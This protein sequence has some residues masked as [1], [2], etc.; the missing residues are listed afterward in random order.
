LTF[1][2]LRKISYFFFFSF[3]LASSLHAQDVRD[4]FSSGTVYDLKKDKSGKIW[5]ATNAGVYVSDGMNYIQI[6]LGDTKTTN[7]SIKELYV[8]NESLFLIFQ[9]SGLM[10]LNTVT[11]SFFKITNMSI[12]SF[13]VEDHKKAMMLTK[14]GGIYSFDIT[15]N[16]NSRMKLLFQFEYDRDNDSRMTFYSKNYIIV[17]ITNKGLFK[18]NKKQWV[19]EKK[20]NI[21]PDGYNNSFTHL[22]DRLFYINQSQV[23]E[24]NKNDQFIKSTYVNKNNN[25]NISYILPISA[26]DKI[27][28]K[29][30]KNLFLES[31]NELIQFNLSKSKNYEIQSAIYLSSDNI[32]F[33]SNQG[34]LKVSN[35]EIK[36]KSISDSVVQMSDYVNIRRKI[37]SYKPN[38]L[39]LFGYPKSHLYNL[40]TNQFTSISNQIN[41]LYDAIVI[42]NTV[43]ATSEGGGVKKIELSNKKISNIVTKDIDTI[44]LYKAILN[45][46]YLIKDHILIG[47]RGEL[48]FYN[49]KNNTSSLLS[50]NNS[51]ARVNSMI[52]DSISK[53]IFIGTSNGLYAYNY[54]NK[55]LIKKTNI[56]GMDIA[57]LA[58][59]RHNTISSLWFISDYGVYAFEIKSNKII[60]DLNLNYFN[61]SKLTSVLIDDE[62][63]I[64]VSSY[65]GIYFF[66]YP[67]VDIIKIN[68]KNGL[69]NQEY[70]YKSSAKLTND[71]LIFGGLNGYDIISSNLFKSKNESLKGKILGYNIYG[72]NSIVYKNYI[73]S[74]IIE[75]NTKNY[76][77]ELYFSMENFEK[78]K[79]SNFEYQIDDRPWVPLLGYSY[80]YMY[81]LKD[82]IHTINIRGFDEEGNPIVFDTI[83]VNQ[84]TDFI[85][86]IT[87]RY[88][89]FTLVIILLISIGI[90]AYNNNKKIN[91]IKS[92]IAMDLHDDI[93]TVLTRAL[94]IIKDDAML[95][96]NNNL[97]NYLSE[98]LFSIRTYINTFVNNQIPI[99]QFIDEIIEHT[100]SYFKNSDI[101]ISLTNNI[102][103]NLD[104]SN[105]LYRDL[106]LIIYEINQ[107]ILKHSNANNVSYSF[108]YLNSQLQIVIKDDGNLNNIKDIEKKGNGITNIRKRV[109]RIKGGVDFQI[110]PIGNGLMIEIKLILDK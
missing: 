14:N 43:Y 65:N 10:K 89:L 75:Y 86:S 85:S 39:L 40:K 42:G 22:N 53:T 11:L 87:L 47:R 48:I 84:R 64:W 35:V 49:I 51:S 102:I 103:N 20:Y 96:N 9:D 110:N 71:Q 25:N 76:Y 27:I 19:I 28:V 58:I 79:S 37:L 55:T 5:L 31:N 26:S 33:G 56:K 38:Q 4:N 66:K 92:D 17:S 91:K 80:L 98:A 60:A 77:L 62:N 34:V 13:F 12:A 46:E 29:A 95:K 52:L 90:F 74:E 44:K 63:K 21:Q 45:I 104:I 1:K 23:F 88:L 100:N 24:I 2:F 57:D 18:L 15:P 36:T 99:F 68:P 78:F 7:S 108:Q 3:F 67:Y 106:K 101:Q 69:I 59:S 30:R 32:I 82:G 81:N 61:N 72:L 41:P 6:N 54:S 83:K 105:F 107:N 73:K 16:S 97:I 70:N 50:L 8:E 93:G 109:N 94:F